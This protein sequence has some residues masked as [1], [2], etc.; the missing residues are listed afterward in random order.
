MHMSFSLIHISLLFGLAFGAD[1]QS[2]LVSE[3][4]KVTNNI[5]ERRAESMGTKLQSFVTMNGRVYED[6]KITQIN[7]G[8]ISFT[9]AA[10]A[11]R[12]RFD[13][14]SPEQRKYFGIA[15]DTAAVIYRR[16]QEARLVYEKQVEVREAARK[17]AAEE[18]AE[19]QRLAAEKAAKERS[20]RAEKLAFRSIP[21]LP[22]VKRVDSGNFSRRS[23]RS[24]RS[25]YG[26]SNYYYPSYYQRSQFSRG[27]GSY[28][29]P[30]TPGF[31]IR[32]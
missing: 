14:L 25:S 3:N 32:W 16:E 20:E 17:K 11:A 29:R 28:C 1:Q 2:G 23:D 10:G 12:L 24:Y 13:D 5:E 8:G 26:Y 30:R 27:S 6:V 4:G 15:E 21:A 18:M 7:D 22:E 31:V 9:H 19:A